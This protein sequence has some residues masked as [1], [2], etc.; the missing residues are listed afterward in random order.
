[1]TGLDAKP[2]NYPKQRKVSGHPIEPFTSIV[3]KGPSFCTP[4]FCTQGD[5]PDLNLLCHAPQ[6]S[7]QAGSPA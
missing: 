3:V 6:P 4:S 5:P 2:S 7:F 1:M